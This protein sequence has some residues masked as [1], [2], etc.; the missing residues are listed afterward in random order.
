VV[1]LTTDKPGTLQALSFCNIHG[2]WE[3]SAE[4]TLA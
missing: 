2:V 1:T 4:V 3:S